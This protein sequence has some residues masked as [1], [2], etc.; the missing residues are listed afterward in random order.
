[1]V[2]YGG[3]PDPFDRVLGSPGSHDCSPVVIDGVID[4][5][6]GEDPTWSGHDELHLPMFVLD[7]VEYVGVT[8]G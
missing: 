3:M 8:Y 5:R 4:L 1:M 7:V 2:V 6:A